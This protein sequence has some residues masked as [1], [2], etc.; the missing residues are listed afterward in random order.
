MAHN[1]ANLNPV[2]PYGKI[3]SAV[4]TLRHHPPRCAGWNHKTDET[5][6]RHAIL[7][8]S[9]D[10]FGNRPAPWAG[11]TINDAFP[12]LGIC[13]CLNKNCST[14]RVG[15]PAA[16]PAVC[17]YTQIPIS[18]ARTALSLPNTGL[19]NRMPSMRQTKGSHIDSNI[20]TS[21]ANAPGI[22]AVSRNSI[23]ISGNGG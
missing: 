21:W 13:I 4:G 11:I 23:S 8:F 20:K 10:V 2:C 1:C 12:L 7:A 15:D 5:C 16:I 6:S 22:P 18:P 3:W 19:T 17:V 14:R 9:N